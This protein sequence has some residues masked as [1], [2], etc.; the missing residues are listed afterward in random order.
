[1][2][3]IFNPLLDMEL[4]K[5]A[6]DSAKSPAPPTHQQQT[7]AQNLSMHDRFLL[8]MLKKLWPKL[9]QYG[10]EGCDAQRRKIYQFMEDIF[11]QAY[12]E[13]ESLLHLAMKSESNR[14]MARIWEIIHKFQLYDVLRLLNDSGESCLH[15]AAALGKAE[16]VKSFIRHGVDVSAVDSKSDTALHVA[17]S[18]NQ[19][20]AV[21]ALLDAPSIDLGVLNDNGY[22]ALHLA[23]KENN[24]RIVEK[25][26]AKASAKSSKAAGIFESVESKHGNNALHIAVEAGARDI[27]KFILENRCVDVNATNLSNHTA[28]VLARAMKDTQMAQMLMDYNAENITDE[29][30]DV[31]PLTSGESRAS[32][33]SGKSDGKIR[34]KMA[35]K[36]ASSAENPT[37]RGKLDNL[38]LTQL[39]DIFNENAKW[40]TVA[41]MLNYQIHIPQWSKLRNPT[42]NMLMVSEVSAF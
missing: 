4:D 2:A 7:L 11:R 29:D 22:S 27:V 5:L 35:G 16:E 17:I 25:L 42:K 34:P 6:T 39:C 21:D 19:I 37:E 1:M 40:K 38:V 14:F 15:V 28:L 18:E 30:E 41:N 3:D 10:N 13:G 36:L 24:L 23:I 33:D 9:V 26:R 8:Q 31:S 12:Y 32:Q 20:E